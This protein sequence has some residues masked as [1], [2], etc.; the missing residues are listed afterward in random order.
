MNFFKY[1]FYYRC[2]KDIK[3][4][5]VLNYIDYNKEEAKKEL[6][7]IGWIEYNNKHEESIF[8]KFLQ[9]FYFFKFNMDKRRY[10]LSS[11]IVSNQITRKKALEI[12]KIKPTFSKR[13]LEY[14]ADKFDLSLKEFQK[15]LNTPIH[16]HNEYKTNTK[17]VK[18]KMKFEKFLPCSD[19]NK[20]RY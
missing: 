14:I 7:Q 9:D 20:I 11:L 3:P 4:I 19:F 18:L 16:E 12:L 6:K 1:N 17:L 10:H 8:T 2:I 15:I 13:D 5:D